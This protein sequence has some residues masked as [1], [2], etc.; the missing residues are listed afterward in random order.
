MLSA[1]I[2]HNIDSDGERTKIF[3]Y[4]A[5]RLDP[6]NPE[7]YRR[8]SAMFMNEGDLTETYM[9][10]RNGF[11]ATGDGKL[12]ELIIE[13]SSQYFGDAWAKAFYYEY[14]PELYSRPYSFAR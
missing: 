5:I 13:I 2:A 1:Y 6:K 14:R 8:L 7:N 10:L 12:F 9:I 4:E 3:L 11:H